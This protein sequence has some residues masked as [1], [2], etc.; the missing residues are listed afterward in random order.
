MRSESGNA[1]WCADLTRDSLAELG[2]WLVATTSRRTLREDEPVFQWTGAG[3]PSPQSQDLD[4]HLR[5]STVVFTEDSWPR[6]VDAA[7]YFCECLRVR[8]ARWN[9][10]VITMKS[11]ASKG[12]PALVLDAVSGTEIPP[13]ELGRNLT[14]FMLSQQGC[15]DEWVHRFDRELPVPDLVPPR[16]PRVRRVQ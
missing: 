3:I 1:N 13:F 15:L 4:S 10:R 9:W 5:N 14:R 8:N 2:P 11:H 12:Q 7:T 6:L 16:P